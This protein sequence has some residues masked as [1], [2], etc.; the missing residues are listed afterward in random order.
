MASQ[1]SALQG[2]LLVDKPGLEAGRQVLDK[3]DCSGPRLPTSHDV[4]QKVRRWSGQRRIGHTGTLDPMASGLLVLC[5]GVATRL[6][7]YYQGHDK[8]YRAE[9][10]L[11]VATDTYDA[12][13]HPTSSQPIPTLDAGTINATLERFRGP[14]LQKP[15]VYSALKQGGESLHRKARRGESVA[16]DPRPV[17]IHELDLLAYEPPKRIQLRLRCS[18]GTYVRS[19]AHDLG[20]ALGTV[21]HLS[22][23]RRE[24]V[25]CFAVTD[26][27]CLSAIEKAAAVGRLSELLLAPGA[28]LTLPQVELDP[29]TSE[30]LGHGQKVWFVP[31]VR[32]Q[33]Q[34]IGAGDLAQGVD[35]Q[36]R[37]IGIVRA[38]EMSSRGDGSLLWKAEKWFAHHLT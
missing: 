24:T 14:I 23:L 20:Q 16:V 12:L 30:R 32:A 11:G 5:L 21:G 19:L 4:V 35:G 28:G 33:G 17:T 36:G 13:G 27:H 1:E 15:P 37:L 25:G 31:S 22:F 18:A 34:S 9:V 8:T 2:I 10:T 29:E 3:A 38:L 26:A 7:E 6:V